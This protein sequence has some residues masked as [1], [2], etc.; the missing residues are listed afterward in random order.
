MILDIPEGRYMVVSDLHGH[1]EDFE[2]VMRKWKAHQAAGETDGLIFLGDLVHGRGKWPDAS[3]SFI[4]TLIELRCNQAGSKVHALL[5]NHELVHIYHAELWS[6]TYCYTEEFE[7]AIAHNRDHYI[8]FLE[9]MPFAIRTE[10]GVL[11]NHTGGSGYLAGLP[12][13]L[14]QPDFT[15]LQNWNH[16][17]VLTRIGGYIGRDFD[18]NTVQQ[19]FKPDLGLNFRPSPEGNFLWEMLMNKNERVY[20]KA[21]SDVLRHTLTFLSEGHASG[22]NLVTCGHIRV[23]EGWQVVN[24]QQLR[25]S[26]TYGAAGDENKTYVIVD[27]ARRYRDAYEL[28]AERRLL[29]S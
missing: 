9:G 4:D 24:P 14:Y 25:L 12:L 13:G 1:A 5:G 22:L 10:G 29:C 3:P 19:S 18:L 8:S 21:Y 11:L 26:T 23:P 17:E 20:N 16:R 7:K 27:A 6:S 28:A 2:L 15:T